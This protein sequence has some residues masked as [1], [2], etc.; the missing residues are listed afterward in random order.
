MRVM[1]EFKRVLAQFG[2][3]YFNRYYSVYKGEVVDNVDPEGAGRLVVKVP[4]VY[5]SQIPDYWAVGKGMFSGN[6]IGF[7]AI[8]NVG[9]SV[10]VCFEQGDPR[11]PI[12][13]YG[14]FTK[15]KIPEGVYNGDDGEPKNSVFQTT[16]GHRIEMDDQNELIRVTDKNGNIIELNSTGASIVSDKISLGQLDGADEPSVLGDT[17]MDL[18]KEFMDDIGTVGTIPTSTGVTATINASPQWAALV[19]KWGQKWE[20]F[21]SNKVTLD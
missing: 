17:A 11:Y 1:V 2:L 3:E 8:P 18:L 21:K 16:S 12:W 20:E 13:E 6:K 4:Q 5:G 14:W 15:K 7:I 19:T 10:W 9:D